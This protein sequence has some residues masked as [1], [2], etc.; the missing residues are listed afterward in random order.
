[1]KI[2]M[3]STDRALLGENI[4]SGDAIQRHRHYAQQVVKLDIIVFSRLGYQTKE[5]AD[6]L[7]CYPTNSSS[8][9]YYLT[10]TIKIAQ[11]LFSQQPY[12]LIVCQDPF[13]T[14]LAG[15]FIKLKFKTKLLVHFH[16]DFWQNRC[17]LKESPFNYLFLFLSKFTIRQATAIRVVSPGIKKKL[18]KKGIAKDKIKVIPTPVNLDKFKNPNNQ[19]V[20]SIKQEFVGKKI[21]LWVGRFSPE[22][23]LDY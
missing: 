21:I 6:N 7:F 23:N 16:G 19:T 14:A 3:I 4:S 9:L 17:W 8:R 5:L 13:L 22:K 18:L 15:Y 2:L 11:Q 12:N 10:Q 1:M 20:A